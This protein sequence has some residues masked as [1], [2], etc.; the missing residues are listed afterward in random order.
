MGR[1]QQKKGNKLR[2]TFKMKTVG[3]YAIVFFSTK[4]FKDVYS[5]YTVCRGKSFFMCLASCSLITQI[6]AIYQAGRNGSQNSSK[7]FPV[8]LSWTKEWPEKK[9][10][11]FFAKLWPNKLSQKNSGGRIC[12]RTREKFSQSTETLKKWSPFV[13]SAQRKPAKLKHVHNTSI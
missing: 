12:V 8:G 5:L 6:T 2:R 11:N 13:Y 4:C 1:K 3:F 10:K 9:K 7:N